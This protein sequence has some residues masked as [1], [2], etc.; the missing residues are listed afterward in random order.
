MTPDEKY[1]QVYRVIEKTQAFMHKRVPP[2][3]KTKL[4][5]D[6]F[7][8]PLQFMESSRIA[9]MRAGLP[10]LDAFYYTMIPHLARTSQC[11]AHGKLPMLDTVSKMAEYLR[12][13]F[14]G[15]H[16]EC[17][18]LILLNNNGRLIQTNLLQKGGVDSAP[19][20]IRPLLF[21]AVQEGAKYIVLA[22]NHPQGTLRPSKEDLICTLRTLNAV[23]PIH[24]S[25]LDHIIIAQQHAVSIRET[26]LI[27]DILWNVSRSKSRI[28]REWLDVD[29]LVE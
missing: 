18:Y 8:S 27:P 22:H 19:F 29:L 28:V 14:I 15:V 2:D 16:V 12:A 9:K 11:Q 23:T 21:A 13:L 17:F 5:R 6:R 7:P 3:E 20:Y 24:V 26:G 25:L 4:I 10:R 1:E